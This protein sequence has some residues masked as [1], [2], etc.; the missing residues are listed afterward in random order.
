MRKVSPLD[1]VRFS[2]RS[3]VDAFADDLLDRELIGN[4]RSILDRLRCPDS[5]ER[6]H[7]NGHG[8]LENQSGTH[9]WRVLGDLPWFASD[10]S[11][12]HADVPEEIM[13]RLIERSMAGDWKSAFRQTL[14]EIDPQRQEPIAENVLDRGRALGTTL[15]PLHASS[16]V[17]DIGCGWG[18][19]LLPVAERVEL[20]VGLDLAGLRARFTQI[21]AHQ[22]GLDNVRVLVGGD[23]PRLP[24]ED[25]LFDAVFL[26]GVLEWTPMTR[27]GKPWNVQRDYLREIRRVLRPGGHVYIGIENRYSLLYLK[28]H[29]EDHVRLRFVSLLPRRLAGPY[30]KMR[31]GHDYRVITHGRGD[32]RKLLREAGFA[33][34]EIFL[35]HPNYRVPTWILHESDHASQRALAAPP[36]RSGLGA[37][38]GRAMVD[39]DLF[40]QCAAGYVVIGRNP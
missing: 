14:E 33:G 12:Y 38:L 4:W 23:R 10:R 8:E 24:F 26:N 34:T 35:A 29:P 9:R 6:L 16:R 20:A 27:E 17:L 25:R 32:Y 36:S 11:H 37:L 21:R 19:L 15:L 1:E 5:G 31:R 3:L 40:A 18:S 22:E 39:S 2:Q 30:V 28:G 13:R 7:E